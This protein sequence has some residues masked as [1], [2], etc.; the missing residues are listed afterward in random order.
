MHNV[1]FRYRKQKLP[2]ICY[3]IHKYSYSP[4]L[5]TALPPYTHPVSEYAVILNNTHVSG[6]FDGDF[7]IWQFGEF[8]FSCQTKD[9]TVNTIFIY[10][11][12]GQCA[13]LNV[14]P[15]VKSHNLMSAECTIHVV[16]CIMFDRE[17]SDKYKSHKKF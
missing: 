2:H 12:L 5:P 14:A 17:N 7:L 16:C 3:T 1:A 9:V 8:F 10:G 15:G 4:F 6:A 11:N 13:K